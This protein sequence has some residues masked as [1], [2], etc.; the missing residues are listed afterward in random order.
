L[1]KK[2]F[3][4]FV[5]TLFNKDW[6]SKNLSKYI[7]PYGDLLKSVK[8]KNVQISN[9]QDKLE[10]ER[11]LNIELMEEMARY[12]EDHEELVKLFGKEVIRN[13]EL[14]NELNRVHLEKKIYGEGN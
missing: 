10:E 6:F 14:Q 5:Y 8:F 13:S 3:D 12:E 4:T 2:H 1:I 9:L 7:Q 11:N